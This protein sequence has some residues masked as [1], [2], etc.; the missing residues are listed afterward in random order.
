[1]K[2]RRIK[3]NNF[4]CFKNE[5]LIFNESSDKNINLILGP[6]G[7]GKTELLFAFR[8]ILSNN[9]DFTK[10]LGKEKT[11]YSLN[12]SLYNDL[13]NGLSAK[14]SC[15]VELELEST[16][17]DSENRVMI[18]KKTDIYTSNPP[19]TPTKDT[20]LELSYLN[21]DGSKS[22]PEKDPVKI[23]EKINSIIPSSIL[24]GIAFDGERM[25]QLSSPQD[26]SKRAIEGL[27]ANIT[28]VEFLTKCKNCFESVQ[29][30]NE[31]QYKKIAKSTK[32]KTLETITNDL[33]KAEDKKKELGNKQTE[34]KEKYENNTLELTTLSNFLKE[35]E[36]TQVYQ[37]EKELFTKELKTWKNSLIDLT[38]GYATA[39]SK[40]YLRA[41]IP[42]YDRALS[43][44]N[45]MAVPRGLTTEAVKNIIKSGKCICGK[46][47]DS[48]VLST[49]EDLL[50]KVPPTNLN[51]TIEQMAGDLK[52]SA[53]TNRKS[54]WNS[55][56]QITTAESEIKE[57][58]NRIAF[59]TSQ[60]GSIDQEKIKEANERFSILTKEQGKLEADKE[61]YS[62]TL[63]NLEH[64]IEVLEKQRETA[65]TH[66]GQLQQLQE[67]RDF[68]KK[69]FYA[70]DLI[71]DSS[72]ERALQILNVKLKEAFSELSSDVAL[73]RRIAL[74]QG[75][76]IHEQYQIISYLQSKFDSELARI[77]NNQK[78]FTLSDKEK[79]ERAIINVAEG[80]S[81]GQS[82]MNTLAFVKAILDYANSQKDDNFLGQA[83]CFPLLI[84]AP[85]GDIFEDNLIQSAKKLHEFSDQ[86]IL[87]LAQ[88]SYDSVK[89]YIGS[90]VNTTYELHKKPNEPYSIIIKKDDK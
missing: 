70:L 41:G 80:N 40:A 72:K 16:Q 86:I 11:P 50:S 1:M 25:Q 59:L 89:K 57:K 42:L 84:D 45:K 67:V 71:S 12:S 34:L 43:S 8:W 78:Y 37:K 2:F 65:A 27:I 69:S 77:Q 60:I 53:E 29:M 48:S 63:E 81:T 83:K 46:E 36:E 3:F 61:S 22:L 51:S 18:L 28:S 75:K 64:T 44:I 62:E 76:G 32:N 14:A 15:S 6:N 58:E 74:I 7:A 5:E 23:N 31:E 85:F 26:T 9:V 10:L 35:K 4:R 49:L 87:F 79:E 24:Y 19:N 55:S 52:T 68:L 20:E 21:D 38:A 13:K 66:N 73:G 30:D 39:L 82:K 90:Y 54:S 56:K 47:I 88:D 17:D 33:K